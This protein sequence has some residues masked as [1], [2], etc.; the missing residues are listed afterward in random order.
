MQIALHVGAHCTDD[1]RL[2]KCLLQNEEL[3]IEQGI[4]VPSPTR[5]RPAIRD[6]LMALQSGTH[7][8]QTVQNHVMGSIAEEDEISRV[9]LSNSNFLSVPNRAVENNMLYTTTGLRGAR[10]RSLFPNCEVAFFLSIRDPATFVPSVFQRS[11]QRDFAHFLN[12]TDPMDLRWSNM[13]M[14]LR[15]A[16]PDAP[17]IVWCN[18]DSPLIWHRVLQAL[19][20]H[21][22]Y[23]DLQGRD[24]FLGELMVKGGLTRMQA[25]LETHHPKSEA[26]R[27]RVVMAFLD[28]FALPDALEEEIDLQGWNEDYMDQLTA[29]YDADIA[30]ISQIPGVTMISP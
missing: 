30:Q 14:R 20:A 4:S 21:D 2:L 8:L 7:D 6:A 10:L 24:D 27:Q 11:K 22:T 19:S 15:Q 18:E 9:V 12:G 5:Y 26:Q 29:I 3:L 25:Y 17:V 16:V 13:I 28:K 1:D 23:T